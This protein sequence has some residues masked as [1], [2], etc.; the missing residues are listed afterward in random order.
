MRKLLFITF[1]V[2]C[3][4]LA[5]TAQTFT[6]LLIGPNEAPAAFD[7]DGMG[8]SVVRIDGTTVHWLV[9]QR[10][11]GPTITGAHIH[12][13]PAGSAAGVALGFSPLNFIDGVA[14]GTATNVDQ[15]LINRIKA[16]PAG[17]YVNVHTPTY[18]GGAIRGQ[19][20]QGC[21]QSDS[22]LCVNSNR[23][24]VNTG[25]SANNQASLG[26]SVKLTGD[27]GYFWF[28]NPENVEI[29]LKSLNACAP[30]FNNHWVFTAGLTNV[31]VDITVIDT[32]TGAFKHYQNPA[33]TDFDP[34]FDTAAFACP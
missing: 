31:A 25:W 16:N 19:L 9:F 13:A 8:V 28:F 6:T 26:H 33:E 2:C 15:A 32:Q 11:I 7:P 22:T 4:P 14:S 27:T 30:P 23:F 21:L 24:R 12:E 18:P 1:V 5:A 34:Q 20:E 29:V 10:E 3:L 17:F